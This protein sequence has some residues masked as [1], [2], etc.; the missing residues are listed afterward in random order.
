MKQC[1]LVALVVFGALLPAAAWCQP[2]PF[3]AIWGGA[4][5]GPGEFERPAG[6]ALDAS[7]NVYVVE[8]VNQRIQVF[9]ADGAYVTRWGSYGHGPGQFAAPMA[10]AVDAVGRVYVADTDNSR[11]QVFTTHGDYLTQWGSD[12]FG[13]GQFYYPRSVAVDAA[14]HVYVVDAGRVE[15]FTPDGVY[16]AQWSI[17]YALAVA[18]GPNGDVWVADGYDW[19]AAFNSTGSMI[20]AWG[21]QGYGPGQF[22]TPS[23]LTVDAHG[24]VYVADTG[25][26]RIQVFTSSGEFVAQWGS[27]GYGQG[28][29]RLPYG[30]AVSEDGRV[31][32]ADTFNNRIQVF[33][34]VPTPAKSTTWGRIKA[35]YR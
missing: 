22:G 28:Q 4:G 3:L 14:G 16:L 15:V 10:V 30:V 34:P 29:F 6:I 31:Y 33:G 17:P 25:G 23:G 24:A 27:E 5:N 7:G 20:K 12:G 11:V 35:L 26:K 8:V 9:T 32:V 2:P 1:L 18:V 13:P 21:S 19:V